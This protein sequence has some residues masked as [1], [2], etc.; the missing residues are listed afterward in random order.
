MPELNFEQVR[1]CINF[2]YHDPDVDQVRIDL[3]CGVLPSVDGLVDLKSLTGYCFSRYLIKNKVLGAKIS[4]A[5]FMNP[6]YLETR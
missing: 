4:P 1:E 2:F 5:G 3:D 6:F